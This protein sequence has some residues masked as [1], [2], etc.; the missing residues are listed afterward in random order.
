MHTG[1]VPQK[2][3]HRHAATTELWSR[4]KGIS[5]VWGATTGLYIASGSYNP[6]SLSLSTRRDRQ[7]GRATT[8]RVEG[9]TH[10]TMNKL[11]GELYVWGQRGRCHV[12][13][14]D[15]QNMSLLS[16]NVVCITAQ[17]EKQVF[18]RQRL[19]ANNMIIYHLY[20]QCNHSVCW[21]GLV[22]V[23]SFYTMIQPQI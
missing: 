23:W 2:C 8:L 18:L 11:R 17:R 15:M 4:S 7:K 10:D 3:T 12:D 13:E 20:F 9:G 5:C 19:A 1:S 6:K 16:G 14:T 22:R 21:C